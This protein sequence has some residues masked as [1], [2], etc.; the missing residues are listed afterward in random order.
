MKRS[1]I[2]RQ[3]IWL[4]DIIS[5]SGGITLQELNERWIKTELSEGVAMTRLTFNRYRTAIEEIFGI[6]IECRRKG[7]QY[8]IENDDILKSNSLIH[9]MIDSLSVGNMLMDSLSM[10]DR[11]LLENIPSGKMHLQPIINAMKQ[12]KKIRIEYQRFGK[13]EVRRI[14]VEPYAIKVF[15]QRWYLL[16]NDNKWE[17]PAVYALDRIV[18]LEETYEKFEYPMDFDA[19]AFFKDCYG[20]LCGTDDKAQKIVLRAYPPYVNYLRTLPL[21]SSQK[22]LDSTPEYADFELYLRP[23]F[24]F[25]QE[26]LC[27]GDEV[28]ILEPK[29]FREEM[30]QMA[31]KIVNRYTNQTK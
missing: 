2:L 24:D 7:Y 19:E 10:K 21:H 26:L 8:F 18:S 1:K 20:V 4:I 16:A 25:R 30:K 31:Q 17:M 15:K 3:Y 22:E 23:T 14:T 12:G 9:W 28:E 5:R 13:Q 29:A 6:N 27:Q 11:I